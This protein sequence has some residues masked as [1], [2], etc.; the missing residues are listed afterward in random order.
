M[1]EKKQIPLKEL[2]T[3]LLFPSTYCTSTH[4]SQHWF[5]YSKKS[6]WM[7]IYCTFL[8][9][10]ILQ[11]IHIFSIKCRKSVNQLRFSLWRFFGWWI[12]FLESPLMPVPVIEMKQQLTRNPYTPTWLYGGIGSFQTKPGMLERGFRI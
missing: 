1:I 8:Y 7:S 11:L 12:S 6:I 5:I 4:N 2:K 10:K 9:S 3:H